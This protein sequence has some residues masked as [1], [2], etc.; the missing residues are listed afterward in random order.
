MDKKNQQILVCS[1]IVAVISVIVIGMIVVQKLERV[2]QVAER[3][4]EKLNSIIKAAS[5]VGK[6]AVEKGVSVMSNIDEEELA[7]SAEDSM[8]EVGA[9]ARDKLFEWIE[10][11]KA[12]PTN[13]EIPNLNITIKTEATE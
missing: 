8:K 1:A 2:V 12:S 5:P 10:S 7:Q 9:V 13:R 3:S 6:A 4:E 11:Q